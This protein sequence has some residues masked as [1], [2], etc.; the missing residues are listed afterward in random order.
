MFSREKR[1]SLIASLT[2]ADNAEL[3]ESLITDLSESDLIIDGAGTLTDEDENSTF[4]PNEVETVSDGFEEKFQAL[5]AKYI[6]RFMNG[7]NVDDLKED[8]LKEDDLKEDDSKSEN[9]SYDD[10]YE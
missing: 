5:Q 4:A 2:T 1:T 6:D 10:L 7:E 3:I 8:D 9:V